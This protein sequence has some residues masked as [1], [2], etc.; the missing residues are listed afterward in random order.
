MDQYMLTVGKPDLQTGATAAGKVTDM[1]HDSMLTLE[2]G[3]SLLL[4]FDLSTGLLRSMQKGPREV[5]VAGP[6]LNLRTRGEAVIYSYH[7]INEYRGWQLDSLDWE[8]KGGRVLIRTHGKVAGTIGVSFTL[9]VDGRGRMDLSYAVDSLPDEYIREVGVMFTLDDGIDAIAWK[10]Q[11]YWSH[12]PDLHLSASEGATP[13]Y[14]EDLKK[15]R[16]IP[17]K[18]WAF[19]TKS[20]Y[21]DGTADELP[22]TG[23]TNRAKG[24]KENI[25]EYSLLMQEQ[26]ILTIHADGDVHCR[27]AKEEGQLHL[28]IDNAMDYVD[29]S[30]GNYQRN[31]RMR[32]RWS[33]SVSVEPFRQQ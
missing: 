22:G 28:Y 13:L 6:L 27:L 2:C 1:Q 23:L 4:H 26:Q 31:L 12:Y 19:D 5:A 30:W 29:L 18:D 15:Y 17:P 8:K 24:T 11:G 3:T 10:R 9:A 33:G 32:G 14:P 21:Y 25:L 16:A 20:F 7:R